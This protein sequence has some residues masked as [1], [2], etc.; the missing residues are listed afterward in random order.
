MKRKFYFVVMA[1]LMALQA[2]FVCASSDE[3]E[4][5]YPSPRTIVNWY[6]EV[7]KK[8]KNTESKSLK[9]TSEKKDDY[10]KNVRIYC[11]K[12][13]KAYNSSEDKTSFKVPVFYVDESETKYWNARFRVLGNSELPKR[14]SKRKTKIKFRQSLD[15]TSPDNREFKKV[16]FDVFCKGNKF[17]LS[18]NDKDLLNQ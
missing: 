14:L 8:G 4:N 1:V 7:L 12:F 6:K 18:I 2:S 11:S 17:L 5:D 3:V 10:I 13:A 16:Q 9:K 15:A